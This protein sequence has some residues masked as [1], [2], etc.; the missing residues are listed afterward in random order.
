M[1]ASVNRISFGSDNGLSP[2]QRQTIIWTSAGLLPIGPLGTTFSVIL[3]KLKKYSR[4][5]IW[6]DRLWKGSHFVQ[7][8]WVNIIVIPVHPTLMS[9]K[10][11]PAK[12]FFSSCEISLWQL[13]YLNYLNSFSSLI[14][15]QIVINLIA[16]QIKHVL[17]MYLI[18]LKTIRTS[19]QTSFAASRLL[20]LKCT[21]HGCNCI[22]QSRHR[23]PSLEL[24]TCIQIMVKN[25]VSKL[26]IDVWPWLW[27]GVGV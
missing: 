17:E 9:D 12:T 8:R 21:Y 25:C 22:V 5:W 19:V 13:Y 6:K 7:G 26:F 1:Y 4:K 24:P 15:H 18:A 23:V 14:I 16:K 11:S 27:S 10:V 20:L 2:I 3:I